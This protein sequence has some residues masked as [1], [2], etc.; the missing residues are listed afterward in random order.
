[1]L[2]LTPD[3]IWRIAACFQESGYKSF[4]PYVA[5]AKEHHILAGY[6]WSEMLGL[7]VVKATHSVARGVGSARQSKPFDLE[8]AVNVIVAGK[9]ALG[10]DAP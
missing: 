4:T 1:M 6:E 7:V 9:V 10:N 5:K 3:K 8:R 2:P